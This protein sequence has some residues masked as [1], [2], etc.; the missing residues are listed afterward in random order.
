MKIDALREKRLSGA[1]LD[2]FAAEPLPASS[3]LRTLPNVLLTPHVGWQVQA[4]LHEFVEIAANQ[5]EAWLNGTLS[6]KVVM[7]PEA[8][9][10]KRKRHGGLSRSAD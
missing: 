3:P 9:L 6:E 8:L 2:V 10:V 4:V 5:C 7:N 1:G